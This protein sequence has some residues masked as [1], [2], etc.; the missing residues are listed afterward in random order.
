MQEVKISVVI[1]TCNRRERLVA[2]L[3]NLDR[4]T[5]PLEE[6]II[7][8]SGEDRLLVEDY[9]NLENLNI[10]YLSSEK[11]VCIQRNIGI[12]KAISP[13]IF[14]CDDDIEVPANYLEKLVA[15]IKIHSDVGAV[16]GLWLQLEKNEWKATYSENSAIG[17]SW[18]FIFKLSIWGEINCTSNNIIVKKIKQHY[19]RKGNHISKAGWPVLTNFS[20]DYFTTPVYS[21]GASLIKSIWLQNSL[22]DEMLDPYGMGDNYGVAIGFPGKIHVLTD[23]MVYHHR[24]ALNRLQK[25]LQYFRRVLA[26]D[27]FIQTKKGL[28]DVKRKWLLWSL[29]GNFLSFILTADFRMAK[30]CLKAI[31]KIASGRNPYCKAIR[32]NRKIVQ[33]TFFNFL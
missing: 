7:V 4:L 3:R 6:V 27:Y 15:H 1:P 22:Y 2:L 11:S 28:K 16:S 10:Q 12:N 24:E 23:T 17:L 25:P 5:Y 19:E 29:T 13:W 8:D 21:L 26:L 18:K 32:S 31:I 33:P 20:N 9:S 30:V 14:L